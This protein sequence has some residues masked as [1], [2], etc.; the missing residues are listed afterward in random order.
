MGKKTFSVDTMR[1]DI[2]LNLKNSTKS[3][4]TPD[5]RQGLMDALEYVLH[6][7]GNYKGFRY[8]L[9]NEVPD[10]ELPGMVVHGTIEDT[11][12][13]VRFAEGTVDRTRVEYF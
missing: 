12:H 7:S 3:Y 9:L 13:E 4:S 2:N 5:V 10:G 11:P 6:Q 8:L 1:R